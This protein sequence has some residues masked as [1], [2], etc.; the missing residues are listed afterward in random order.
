MQGSESES[1]FDE[2]PQ[3]TPL[4]HYRT[5]APAPQVPQST[6]VQI[7][8]RLP[9]VTA[10]ELEKDEDVQQK[11]H[12]EP[13]VVFLEKT[14]N[15]STTILGKFEGIGKTKKL[16]KTGNSRIQSSGSPPF[17]LEKGEKIQI[18][19]EDK[20][21]RKESK[22][23]QQ[24]KEPKK[25]EKNKKPHRK[26]S[27]NLTYSEKLNRLKLRSTIKTA[28]LT[29]SLALSISYSGYYEVIGNVMAKPLT[30][31]VFK[32]SEEDQLSTIGF[33]YTSLA[34]G[35][36]LGNLAIPLFSKGLGRIRTFILFELLKI[37]GGLVFQIKNLNLVLIMIMG[38]GFLDAVQEAIVMLVL[39]EQLPPKISDKLGFFYYIIISGF[40]LV[41]SSMN[42]VFGGD[43]GLAENWKLVLAW[44][45]L[46]SVVSIV[47]I[48]GTVGFVETPQYYIENEADLKKLQKLI[49][50]SIRKIYTDESS[51]KFIR[52]KFN[53]I[54]KKKVYEEKIRKKLEK[55]QKQEKSQ[56]NDEK[57]KN[58]KMPKVNQATSMGWSN[59]FSINYR[60]QLM[61][62][63]LLAFFKSTMGIIL[64]LFFSTLIFDNLMNKGQVITMIVNVAYVV[65]AF[66]SFISSLWGRRTGFLISSIISSASML[67]IVIGVS[68]RDLRVIIGSIFMFVLSYTCGLGA[69]S[70]VYLVDILPPFGLGVI[71]TLQWTLVGGV[72]AIIPTAL[73]RYGAEGVFGVAFVICCLMLSFQYL[74][75]IETRGLSVE[76]VE[77]A[78]MKQKSVC[79]FT[80]PRLAGS[81]SSKKSSIRNGFLEGAFGDLGVEEGKVTVG[82]GLGDAGDTERDGDRGR[83]AGGGA[84]ALNGFE[85]ARSTQRLVERPGRG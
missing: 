26:G 85:T 24:K 65:G 8:E 82:G 16:P 3:D 54:L 32:L 38:T 73:G 67:L 25:A 36:I 70:R 35:C 5:P 49:Y 83:G 15:Q 60:R 52:Y 61:V 23:S 77:L 57:Q 41:A 42:Y 7:T 47:G 66:L 12:Q 18:K 50:N 40:A 14:K 13:E 75:C 64:L 17:E 78:F 71:Y 84:G 69:T 31:R 33:M 34:A 81:T 29:I 55:K 44:P 56:K 2:I 62:G 45:S 22:E 11:E 20:K 4:Q 19:Q 63:C 10:R 37:L 80:Q 68:T 43:E 28:I 53:E 76:E 46:V 48:L 79:Y 72:S 51:E 27:K 39:K 74:Y 6:E 59:M 30:Q 1:S 21:E 58:S 9:L